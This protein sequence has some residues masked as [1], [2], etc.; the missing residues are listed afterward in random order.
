MY[1]KDQYPNCN[2]MQR[3]KFLFTLLLVSFLNVSN[4]YCQNQNNY[5]QNDTMITVGVEFVSKSD[6]SNAKYIEVQEFEKIVRY[7]PA[8]LTEYGFD[9]GRVYE[10]RNI[11]VDNNVKKVFLERVVSGKLI[12]YRYINEDQEIFYLSENARNLVDL[13]NS[14]EKLA[15]FL[16]D[17]KF[18]ED[19]LK[20]SK[21][22]KKSLKTLIENY[23]DCKP[24]LFPFTKIGLIVG[25]SQNQLI[26]GANF[27]YNLYDDIQLSTSSFLF[28]V[29]FDTPLAMSN[30]SFV[31]GLNFQK[32]GYSSRVTNEN[33]EFDV[34]LNHNSVRLPF[35]LRY[36]I[37][38]TG[39]RPFFNIGGNLK[40]NFVNKSSVYE[41]NK[42]GGT[43]VI[44]K[45][46]SVSPISDYL[47]GYSIGGGIE[48]NLD[49]RRILSAELRFYQLVG[50]RNNSLSENSIQLVMGVSF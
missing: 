5:I 27:T 12:L 36:R 34:L 2:L 47:Y 14:K 18:I 9:D 8:E 23:N 11:T 7:T 41:S 32:S 21:F 48:Y 46:D 45:K 25:R 39:F 13:E 1:R 10:S 29:Y 35:F 16:K 42:V 37:D 19:W 38:K 20:L 4:S 30:Y 33:T 43:I 50:A 17:C 31:L 22:N 3:A 15:R 49:Y 28:G 40:Y 26:S 6:I 44:D 24:R